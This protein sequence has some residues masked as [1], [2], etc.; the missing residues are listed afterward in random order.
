M[1]VYFA[2]IRAIDLNAARD[3]SPALE[4]PTKQ[5][6]VIVL[7]NNFAEAGRLVED[8]YTDV[9]HLRRAFKSYDV[10]MSEK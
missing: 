5:V 10:L 3:Y 1:K 8:R 6:E 4:S 9:M 2:T 7:A